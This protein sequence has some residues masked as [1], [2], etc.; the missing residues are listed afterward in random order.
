MNVTGMCDKMA[1]D[2]THNMAVTGRLLEI[3]SHL[4]EC[5][6][7]RN[8]DDE[9]HIDAIAESAIRIQGQLE[10]LAVLEPL[11]REMLAMLKESEPE[12]AEWIERAEKVLR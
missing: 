4:E 9:E 11:A 1:A 6:V 3:F 12:C 8:P 7:S 5:R 2:C 10:R